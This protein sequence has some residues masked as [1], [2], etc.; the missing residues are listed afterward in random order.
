VQVWLAKEENQIMLKIVTVFIAVAIGLASPLAGAGNGS[1]R[2]LKSRVSQYC[3]P[4]D[5]APDG[6]TLYC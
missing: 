6:P 5:Q 4:E 3:A 2:N 1:D